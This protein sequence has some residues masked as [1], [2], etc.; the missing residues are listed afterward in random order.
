MGFPPTAGQLRVAAARCAVREFAVGAGE[1]VVLDGVVAAPD[2]HRLRLAAQS[3][4][5]PDPRAAHCL[6]DP[7]GIAADRRRDHLEGALHAR[8]QPG[9]LGLAGAR[10]EYPGADHLAR[11]GADRDHHRRYLGV[12]S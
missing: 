4:E 5:R 1:T 3:E 9:A 12:V 10:L 6:P 11:L 7:D 8:Y 2:R